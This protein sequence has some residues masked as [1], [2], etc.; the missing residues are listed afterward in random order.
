MGCEVLLKQA[1]RR[2]IGSPVHLDVPADAAAGRYRF[3][4]YATS[5]GLDGTLTPFTGT[6]DEFEIA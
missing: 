3:Q 4:R 1:R 6:T 2:R 5:L